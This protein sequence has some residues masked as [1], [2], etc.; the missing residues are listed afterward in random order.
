MHSFV[1]PGLFHISAETTECLIFCGFKTFQ[2][3][4]CFFLVAF[5]LAIIQPAKETTIKELQGSP[6]ISNRLN[7][8]GVVTPFLSSPSACRTTGASKNRDCCHQ[9]GVIYK[10][11]RTVPFRPIFLES[12]TIDGNPRSSF[13]VVSLQPAQKPVITEGNICFNCPLPGILLL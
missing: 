6:S 7:Q 13:I 9:N 10:L 8:R 4:A 11:C 5:V 2:K 3:I 1:K 12:V